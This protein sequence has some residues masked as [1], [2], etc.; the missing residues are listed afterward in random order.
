MLDDAGKYSE[1]G[2]VPVGTRG[3]YVSILKKGMV[4]LKLDCGLLVELN[5]DSFQDKWRCES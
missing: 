3:Q 5:V 2:R 1:S 4:T